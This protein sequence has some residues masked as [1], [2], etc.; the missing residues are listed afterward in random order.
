ME[1]LLVTR[2]EYTVGDLTAEIGELLTD[3]YSGI[4]VR[5]EVS[6]FKMAASG[7][8]YFTLKDD[9]AVLRAACWKG[10]YRFV[11]FKPRDG[12]A[13]LV[14]GRIEVYEPRGEYQLIVDAIEAA[15]AGALQA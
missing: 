12:D 9:R 11:K 14:R 8:A 7:H 1:P 15:G 2:R 10:T 4:W 6:G 13:V 3:A 5:G